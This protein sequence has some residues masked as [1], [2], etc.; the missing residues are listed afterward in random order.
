M[1]RIIFTYRITPQ[2]PANTSP[3]ELLIKR[4]PK[5]TIDLVRPDL[6]SIVNAKQQ[7]QYHDIHSKQREYS[8]GDN[9]FA[10]IHARNSQTWLPSTITAITGP[11]SYVVQLDYGC[12]QRCHINQLRA[13]HNNAPQTEMNIPGNV[14]VPTI[15]DVCTYFKKGEC[16]T[17]VNHLIQVSKGIQYPNDVGL[18]LQITKSYYSSFTIEIYKMADLLFLINEFFRL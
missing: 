13:R 18:S 3:A 11:L 16:Y 12:T 17:S 7:I 15:P 14:F 10:L 9:V 4:K 2:T 1:S 8:I 5:S 6:T